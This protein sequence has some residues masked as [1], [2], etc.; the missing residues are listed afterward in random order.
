[1]RGRVATLLTGTLATMLF[2]ATPALADDSKEVTSPDGAARVSYHAEGDTFWLYDLKC[3]GHDVE[4]YYEV[5]TGEAGGDSFG[6][7]D[8]RRK[9]EHNVTDDRSIKFCVHRKGG[10]WGCEV[11]HT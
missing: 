11:H 8:E 3:D 1:M 2:A 7:C 6:G 10:P 5:S 4:Y 9:F